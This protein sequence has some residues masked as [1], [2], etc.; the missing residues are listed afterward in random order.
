MP[1]GD[2]GRIARP[3]GDITEG[4]SRYGGTDKGGA[5]TVP[6]KEV[7]EASD[8]GTQAESTTTED[9]HVTRKRLGCCAGWPKPCPYHEGYSDAYD[10]LQAEVTRL[11]DENRQLDSII[12]EAFGKAQKVGPQLRP[13]RDGTVDYLA[14]DAD[15]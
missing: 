9:R 10:V 11:K 7:T 6:A 3:G 12:R 13:L 14:G 4:I 1:S 5:M 15:D 2:Q 8:E